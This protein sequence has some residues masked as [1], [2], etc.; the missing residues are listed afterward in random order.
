MSEPNATDEPLRASEGAQPE[1]GSENVVPE[2]E[3]DAFGMF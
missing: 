2:T 3:E 1:P